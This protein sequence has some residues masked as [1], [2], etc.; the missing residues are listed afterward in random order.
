VIDERSVLNDMDKVVGIDLGTTNSVIAVME[1]GRPTV[2]A[3]L[4]GHRLTPSIVAYNINKDCFVGRMAKRQAVTNP[5]NTFYSVK[6]FIGRRANEVGIER[7]QVSYKTLADR[8]NMIKIDCPILGQH[9]TPEEISARILSNLVEYAS[10]YIG[11]PVKKAVITVPAYFNESQRE[12]TKAAGRI[13]GLDVLKIIN[14]PTAASLAY[15]LKRGKKE[16]VL[17]FDLGGGTFDASILQTGDGVF[18]VLATTGDT[19]LGGDDFDQKI[20]NWLVQEFKKAEGIDLSNQPEAKRRLIEAAENAKIHL[21]TY[22][23]VEIN[24]PFISRIGTQ[25]KSLE[26]IL[27]RVKFESLCADL[28]QRCRIPVEMALQDAGLKASQID[29]VVLAGGATRIPAIQKLVQDLLSKQPNQSV[30]PDE[31]VAVGAAIQAGI[32][33][34][35]LTFRIM[36]VTPLSLGISTDGGKMTVIVPRNTK[37]PARR[38]RT[39][40]TARDNQTSAP[41]CIYQGEYEEVGKNTFLHEFKLDGIPPAPRGVPKIQVTYEID[42]DGILQVVAENRET[43][44]SRLVDIRLLKFIEELKKEVIRDFPPQSRR[45]VEAILKDV[46]DELTKPNKNFDKLKELF[47]KL[48]EISDIVQAG[49]IVVGTIIALAKMCGI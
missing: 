13:A 15:S 32:L 4:D 34:G 37:L 31:V 29:Q 30:N 45:D 38:T 22:Q 10:K 11:E 43:G 41:I 47:R 39:I 35:E 42:E 25:L 6:R 28:I 24:L 1:G 9:F 21:S 5:G 7:E 27:T 36:D 33:S 23:E 20:V 12:A 14:E 8:D 48:K 3:D 2:I 49:G 44:H 18:D 19:H 26:M 16:T 40:S 46:E 17:V